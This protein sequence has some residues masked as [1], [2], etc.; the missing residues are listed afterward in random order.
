MPRRA[1][2]TPSEVAPKLIDCVST[3][4]PQLSASLE[5]WVADYSRDAP[6]AIAELLSFLVQASGLPGAK[7]D[8][9]CAIDTLFLLESFFNKDVGTFDS[10][11]KLCY[12]LRDIFEPNGPGEAPPA[13]APAP[14]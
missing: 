3:Q 10:H 1:S 7:L 5:R 4:G 6:A 12:W 2:T 11:E 8:L 14:A 13:P 9:E